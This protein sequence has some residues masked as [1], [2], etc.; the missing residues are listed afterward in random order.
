[1]WRGEWKSQIVACLLVHQNKFICVCVIDDKGGC[2]LWR[3]CVKSTIKNLAVHF[4]LRISDEILRLLFLGQDP[5]S[6]L[7]YKLVEENAWNYASNLCTDMCKT[8]FIIL[9]VKFYHEVGPRWK[10]PFRAFFLSM[11]YIFTMQNIG[12][13]QSF[14]NID[15]KVGSIWFLKKLHKF[16]CTKSRP[17]SSHK[18]HFHCLKVWLN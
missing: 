9:E 12:P 14:L 5:I 3:R 10:T 8:I 11:V 4:F 1:M 18:L 7:G 16:V 6:Q 17:C 13:L 2:G 15:H